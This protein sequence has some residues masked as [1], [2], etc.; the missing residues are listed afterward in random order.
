MTEEG[1]IESEAAGDVLVLRAGGEWRL[2]GAAALDAKLAALRSAPGT[3]G[4]LRSRRH[5]VARYGRGVARPAPAARPYRARQRCDDR[6]SRRR[7]RAA[8]APGGK[9]SPR[10]GR[11]AP[12]HRRH[13]RHR[14]RLGCE[15]DRVLRH[16]LRARGLPGTGGA[17]APW[18]ACA[19]P[20]ASGS[21]R[22]GAYGP[23]RRRGTADRRAAFVPGGHGHGVPGRPAAPPLRRGDFRRRPA[24]HRLFARDGRA[25]DGHHRRRPLGQRLHRRDRRDAGERG[26]RRAAHAGARPDRAPGAAAD[27]R[28]V[29][30]AAA[31]APFTPT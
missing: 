28:A 21:P 31:A 2:G 29:A 19:I 7:S 12:P 15:D 23:R 26:D 9:R 17:A 20:G 30:D 3:P 4:A 18:H 14:R 6:E 16:R 22:S 24:G 8:L 27:A 5:R 13:R 11:A 25:V 10:R 1:W